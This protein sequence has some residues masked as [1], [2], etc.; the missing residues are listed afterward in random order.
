MET[1]QLNRIHYFW[2]SKG[3]DIFLH[4]FIFDFITTAALNRFLVSKDVGRP[5]LLLLVDVV[6]PLL[7]FRPDLSFDKL[8]SEKKQISIAVKSLI[9]RI[10]G[11]E[12]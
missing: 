12:P 1:Y 7:T 5:P 8:C 3:H 9:K 10:S 2:K 11:Q 4:N 6:R